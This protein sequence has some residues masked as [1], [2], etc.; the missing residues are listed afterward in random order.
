MSSELQDFYFAFVLIIFTH[1]NSQLEQPRSLPHFVWMHSSGHHVS[2][3]KFRL[4]G[5]TLQSLE[6]FDVVCHL[7]ESLQRNFPFQLDCDLYL[8]WA[9][10]A[11]KGAIQD[12]FMDCKYQSH[13]NMGHCWNSNSIHYTDQ[14]WGL[15]PF[16]YSFPLKMLW[17]GKTLGFAACHLSFQGYKRA[18]EKGCK[19]PFI[20]QNKEV[21]F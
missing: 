11:E 14:V 18:L 13:K 19:F 2:T 9:T 3:G 12:I 16:I 5:C 4:E 15:T 1:P 7:S 17:V 8:E 10:A 21:Y 20:G 6:P